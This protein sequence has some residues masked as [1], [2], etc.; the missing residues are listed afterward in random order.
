[1]LII[2]LLFMLFLGLLDAQMLSPLLPALAKEFEVDA[3]IMGTVVTA[4]AFAA[5]VCALVIGPLSDRWGRLI[6]LRAAIMLLGLTSLTAYFAPRFEIYFGARLLA[7][8]AGGTISACV[9]AQIADSFTF[10]RRGR[11]MGWVGAIYSLAAVLGVPAAAWVAGQWSWRI[12][13]AA[14]AIIALLLALFLRQRGVAPARHAIDV[15]QILTDH[16]HFWRESHTRSGLLLAATISAAVAAL[17]TYLGIYLNESFG[18][19]ITAIGFVFLAAGAASTLGALAGGIA[20][21]RFGKQRMITITSLMLMLILPALTFAHSTLQLYLVVAAA[22]LVLAGREGPYQAL[23]SELVVSSQRGAYIA[24]R[25][26]ASQ[27]AIAAS[28]A[29]AA[30][31]YHRNGF[32]L[33]TIYAATLSLASAVLVW[34]IKEPASEAHF[35]NPSPTNLSKP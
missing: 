1:M 24:V 8:L 5:A 12:I 9:L 30:W 16:L 25:N 2:Q 23:I 26:A 33:V 11:A 28:V 18:M 10:Q 32:E 22:G 14:M 34:L 19:S 13:Y 21:D 17:L 7:G 27:I 20:S 4:Y 15:H 35:T 31:L 29:G 3:A 6:F